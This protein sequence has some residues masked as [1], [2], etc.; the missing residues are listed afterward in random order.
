V[1]P[2]VRTQARTDPGH[3]ALTFRA[4]PA[5]PGT[6]AVV[7]GSVADGD[8]CN[9]DEGDILLVP[10]RLHHLPGPVM[11]GQSCYADGDTANGETAPTNRANQLA[12]PSFA[13]TRPFPENGNE[14]EWER[15]GGRE[16]T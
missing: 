5:S 16:G 3:A 15:E 7:E 14:W 4:R 1:T 13:L 11:G 12:G 10:Q 8:G 6:E 2:A 9:D